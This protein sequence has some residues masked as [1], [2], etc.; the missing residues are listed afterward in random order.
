MKDMSNWKD[1]DE[2]LPSNKLKKL[3]EKFRFNLQVI[4]SFGNI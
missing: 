4:F 2:N 3:V 1:T